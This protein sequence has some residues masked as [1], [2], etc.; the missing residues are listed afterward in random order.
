MK[1]EDRPGHNVVLGQGKAGMAKFLREIVAAGFDGL[2]AIEYEEGDD[3][4]E[5]V[6]ECVRFIRRHLRVY[7]S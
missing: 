3:P 1:D 2:A 7:S 5:E 4:R 6:A